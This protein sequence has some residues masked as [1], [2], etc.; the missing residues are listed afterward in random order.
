[1]KKIKIA[2]ALMSCV[3]L[4]GSII[5]CS[6]NK[7]GSDSGTQNKAAVNYDSGKSDKGDSGKS[8]DS[9]K[10]DEEFKPYQLF[11]DSMSEQELFDFCHKN[12]TLQLIDGETE[13]QLEARLPSQEMGV[14]PFGFSVSGSLVFEYCGAVHTDKRNYVEEL[15]F[16]CNY[17]MATEVITNLDKETGG[18]IA[19]QSTMTIYIYD[20]K[21]QSLFDFFKSKYTEMYPGGDI[22]GTDKSDEGWVD[23]NIETADGV[24]SRVRLTKS[25]DH[26][27]LLVEESNFFVD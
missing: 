16:C 3:L 12:L 25:A 8:N 9:A 2:C 14:Q 17:D 20:D 18:I 22:G 26:E 15:S 1:M 7:T 4:D 24:Y 23:F 10:G 27:E 13:S 11:V 6:G 19:R 21:G 5:G